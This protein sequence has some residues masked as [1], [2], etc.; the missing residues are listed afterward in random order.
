MATGDSIDDDGESV[1]IGFGQL[2]G[3]VTAGTVATTTV[4]ITDDDTANLVLSRAALTVGEAGTGDFTVR[5]ATQPTDT[6]TVSA[7]SG[8][9]E[10]A[11]VPASSLS[12]TT[13]NWSAAQTVTV[14]GVDDPDSTDESVTVSLSAMNGGYSGR[15]A[16]VTVNVVD[17]DGLR[18]VSVSFGQTSYRVSEGS[19]VDVEVRFSEPPQRAVQVPITATG[20]GGATT[21]DYSGVPASVTFGASDTGKSFTFSALSD[22]AEDDG[23]A[24]ELGFGSMPEGVTA[25]S[26]ARATVTIDDSGDSSGQ[27]G[28]TVSLRATPAV[29]Q[30]PGGGRP[31]TT[32][33]TAILDRSSDTDTTVTISTSPTSAT[34]MSLSANRELVI[35]A[36]SSTSTGVVTVTALNDENF[37]GRRV[38]IVEGVSQNS[39]GVSG[40]TPVTV[41][42]LASDLNVIPYSENG[43]VPVTG[44]TS[45]DPEVGRPGEGIDWDLTGMD[46]DDFLID[47]RGLL[48]F[49]RA[50]RLRG[51]NRPGTQ[52]R[53][54]E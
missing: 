5:L 6:V 2:P 25:G 22:S 46:A 34:W 29:I 7:T 48:I 12:F 1:K 13:S 41:T 8:D 10:A 18:S 11:T 36:G 38:I 39:E 30:E 9:P 37:A 3:G 16:T 23:E 54:P 31:S 15:G 32:T 51:P 40:P 14:S 49:R 20:E 44:F 17:D 45:T 21:S 26:P 33:V 43:T 35:P 52:R 28:R 42:V 24:V 50:S 27:E 53:R 19:E 47:P 4:A